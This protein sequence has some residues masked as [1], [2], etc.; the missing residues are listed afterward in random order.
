MRIP[1]IVCHEHIYIYIY[2]EDAYGGASPHPKHLAVP[3]LGA[4]VTGAVLRC[5]REFGPLWDIG[6]SVP[7][8][9][10]R[11]RTAGTCLQSC[12][13]GPHGVCPCSP[14]A[15]LLGSP[16][17]LLA[18]PLQFSWSPPGVPL[19]C[20]CRF[21]AVPLE[22]SCSP[23]AVVLQSP[24]S[25]HA[26]SLQPV[27]NHPAGSLQT[28]AGPAG[29]PAV[30][31]PLQ[32]PC[33][34]PCNFYLPGSILLPL[35]LSSFP[36]VPL[37]FSCSLRAVFSESPCSGPAVPSEFP[38]QSP[39]TSCSPCRHPCSAPHSSNP[40]RREPFVARGDRILK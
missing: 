3:A 37:H 18:V 1:S 12:P 34:P 28:A 27:C 14:P 22:S 40:F 29:P 20:P 36:S 33:R 9:F 38:L 2:I 13:A 8:S 6:R 10:E 25:P 39:C 16:C 5:G 21:P 30:P 15:E 31:S 35:S 23:P 24:W 17:S 26:V 19:Q 11:N 4:A 7:G 32:R